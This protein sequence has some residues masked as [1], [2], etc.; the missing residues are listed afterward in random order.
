M[1]DVGVV[2]KDSLN[3]QQNFKY[4]G[5]DAVINA[6]NPAFIKH[7]LFVVPEVMDQTRRNAGLQRAGCFY[8]R[9]A[10]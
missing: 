6:L 4:R 3:K 1:E 2:G 7:H 5:I 10:V 8:I 9:S